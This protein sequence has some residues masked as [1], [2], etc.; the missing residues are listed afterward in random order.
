MA[1]QYHGAVGGRGYHPGSYSHGKQKKCNQEEA[2]FVGNLNISCKES[3]LFEKFSTCGTVSNIRLM[4]TRKKSSLGYAFVTMATREESLVA[5]CKLNNQELCGCAMRIGLG[6]PENKSHASIDSQFRNN[7]ILFR[8]FIPKPETDDTGT[9]TGAGAPIL[10]AAVSDN[11]HSI[12]ADGKVGAADASTTNGNP[13][14]TSETFGEQFIKEYINDYCKCDA[15]SEANIRRIFDDEMGEKVCLNVLENIS[16]FQYQG[17]FY[18]IELSK[19]LQEQLNTLGYQINRKPADACTSSNDFFAK[20]VGEGKPLNPSG[21]GNPD[22]Q[23]MVDLNVDTVKS[24]L[25]NLSML[26]QTTPKIAGLSNS[27]ELQQDSLNMHA[28]LRSMQTMPAVASKQAQSKPV[29]GGV[30]GA[31][32]GYQ[33]Q[34]PQQQPYPYHHQHHQQRSSFKSN[35]HHVPVHQP[36]QSYPAPGARGWVGAA[37]VQSV[38]GYTQ[39]QT[40]S[41][42]AYGQYV[43]PQPPSSRPGLQSGP[44]PQHL[45]F[46]DHYGQ[47][48]G[49]GA[50]AGTT[51]FSGV[52]QHQHQHQLNPV[53]IQQSYMSNPQSLVPGEGATQSLFFTPMEHNNVGFPSNPR[54]QGI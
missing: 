2:L 32:Y 49:P 9:G 14:V 42:R 15:I 29:H 30:Q 38:Q 3:D 8:F 54:K 1:H 26:L 12:T 18:S 19:S 46:P 39:P 20:I 45:S 41:H 43:R 31:G 34:P 22:E 51:V 4:K 27:N 5:L 53:G 28:K 37:P 7:S 50:S 36:Q 16:S 47:S 35:R 21:A 23:S 25:T 11:E 40:N 10:S 44:G 48:L 13:V 6:A 33:H 17:V 24:S 52:I